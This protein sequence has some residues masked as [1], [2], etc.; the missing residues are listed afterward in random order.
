MKTV[1]SFFRIISLTEEL[2]DANQK[3][4]DLQTKI[5]QNE[6]NLEMLKERKRFVSVVK[7]REINLLFH[8]NK[9]V[10]VKFMNK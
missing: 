1:L 6:N 7:F 5:K 3:I 2:K 10:Y 8:T 9:W 4:E